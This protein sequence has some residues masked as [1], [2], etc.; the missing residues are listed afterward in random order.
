MI[1]HRIKAGLCFLIVIILAALRV[2]YADYDYTY[3]YYEVYNQ[4][5][6]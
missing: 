6:F 2:T 3:Y 5:R 4:V 1:S